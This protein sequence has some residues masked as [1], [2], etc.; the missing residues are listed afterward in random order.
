M[1]DWNSWLNKKV[2]VQT[3]TGSKYTGIILD[4][5]KTSPP[6]IF[7]TL[8]DKFGMLVTIVSSEIIKIMEWRD[9]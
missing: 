5:D 7:L 4:V 8:R 9:E 2:F 6:I 3:R 1:I